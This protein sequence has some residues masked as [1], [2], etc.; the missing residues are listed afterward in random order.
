MRNHQ[1]EIQATHAETLRAVGEAADLWGGEWHRLGSGGALGLPVSAGLR[2]G[3]LKGQVSTERS[4]NGTRLVYHVQESHY[5][6]RLAHFFVLLVGGIGGVVT[7]LVPFFPGLVGLV[8][9]AGLLLLLAWFLV[10]SRLN[11][12]GVEEFLDLVRDLAEGGEVQEPEAGQ[13][14]LERRRSREGT[15]ARV[16]RGIGSGGEGEPSD[17][18]TPA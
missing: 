6:L 8:P 14:R 13:A 2:L 10:A 15:G 5:R 11:S 16:S 18:A 12:S 1:V 9:L 3:E 7:V 4:A 17:D